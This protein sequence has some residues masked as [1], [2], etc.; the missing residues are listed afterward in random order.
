MSSYVIPNVASILAS[1]GSDS[2]SITIRGV[3]FF[4]PLVSEVE[5][6]YIADETTSATVWSFETGYLC[7]VSPVSSTVITGTCNPP[8]EVYD[9]PPRR[10][11]RLYLP[12]SEKIYNTLQLKDPSDYY[13][14]P[15]MQPLTVVQLT[16]DKIIPTR[17]PATPGTNCTLEGV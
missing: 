11:M 6:W 1:S 2:F 5:T 9:L 14:T 8:Y 17:G 3:N 12:T 10:Q 4:S 7:S 13:V 16:I 15:V